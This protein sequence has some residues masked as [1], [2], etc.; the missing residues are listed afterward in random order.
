MMVRPNINFM[1]LILFA[2]PVLTYTGRSILLIVWFLVVLIYSFNRKPINFPWKKLLIITLPFTIAATSLL[3]SQN[4]DVG[5]K[6][7]TQLLPLFIVPLG[8]SLQGNINSDNFIRNAKFIFCISVILFFIGIS[9]ICLSHY[10]YL[11]AAPS[12]KELLYNGLTHETLSLSDI[13]EIKLRRFRQFIEER[14]GSHSTYSGSFIVISLFILA[15]FIL[16]SKNNIKRFLFLLLAVFLFVWLIALAARGPFIFMFVAVIITALLRQKFKLVGATAILFLLL[17]SVSYFSFPSFKS[18]IDDLNI[19]NYELPKK[20]NDVTSFNA[21][22][23]R[24]G[25][26]YC[27]LEIFKEHP[28]IG[29]GV[30]DIQNDLNNC[31][32]SKIGAS[33]YTW[34]DYNSHNQY[35]FYLASCGLIGLGLFLFSI[36][37]NFNGSFSLKD[38]FL[39]FFIIYIG[40]IF[41][42]ENFICRNDGNMLYSL[43]IALFLFK[44]RRE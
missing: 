9:I 43:F 35:L 33:I 34:R 41:L 15:Q 30:G 21:T 31:Y 39:N 18:R 38:P 11:I 26:Y 12:D 19:S 1:P 36:F 25:C 23:V 14:S 3:Y 17:F 20:G 24:L 32:A 8:F 22:N 28:V 4:L 6:K 5:V 42:T 16:S 27:S 2:F 10:D 37:Y 40:L 7:V 44:G 13:T 29:V